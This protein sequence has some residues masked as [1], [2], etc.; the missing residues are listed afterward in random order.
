L[1]LHW[2]FIVHLQNTRTGPKVAQFPHAKKPALSSGLMQ[3]SF[4]GPSENVTFF[5]MLGYIKALP[6][7]LRG[8]PKAKGALQGK[9][10]DILPVLKGRDS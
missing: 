1:V 8:G 6:L 3:G 5:S 7:D 2:R 4:R 10:V 9:A